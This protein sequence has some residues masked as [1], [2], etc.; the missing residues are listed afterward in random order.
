VAG[1]ESLFS[2]ETKPS[3]PSPT[4]KAK[5]QPTTQDEASR[6]YYATKDGLTV[7]DYY[8]SFEQ[9]ADGYWLAFIEKQ[10]PYGDRKTDGH[11][12]HRLTEDGRKY[13]CWDSP[14]ESL[15]A[16][17]QVAA[18]WADATQEYIRTGKNF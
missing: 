17:H 11:S 5:T 15:E 16:C 4:T 1:I 13:V 12:T 7:T 9:D 3:S 8:F 6:S 2:N 18:L 10:P 14:I